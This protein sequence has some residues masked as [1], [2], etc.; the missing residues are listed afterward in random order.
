MS[1]ENVERTREAVEAINRGDIEAAFERTH[2]D[3]EWQT[4][5]LFPD[6]GT[7]RGTDEVLGF[8][9][10][11]QEI[12]RGF[13]LH[14]EECVPVDD[15]QVLAALRVGGEGAESGVEVESPVFFQVLE[16]RDGRMIRARMFQ[17]R[18]EALEAA[19]RSEDV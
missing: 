9:R 12:F 5:D 7:Y 19:G 11:W 8:F 1:N 2:P 16:F 13:H 15:D 3:I 4:L 17:T 6:A 18:S 10:T 14:L